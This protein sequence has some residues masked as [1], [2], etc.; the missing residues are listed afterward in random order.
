MAWWEVPV[1]IAIPLG[2]SFAINA[3]TGPPGDWYK[4]LNKPSWTPP[5][6]VFPVMWT[7]L[8]VLMG[9]A[10]WLVWSQGG[11]EE[12]TLPLSFYIAQLALNFLWT[13]LFFG[14]HQIGLAL[15]EIVLMWLAI[16]ATIFT[17]WGVSKTAAI[18]LLPYICWVSVATALNYSIYANNPAQGDS[19]SLTHPLNPSQ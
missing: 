10:S 15:V 12:Q 2:G 16:A 9:I 3:I 19:G 8:Y 11:F 4:S 1:A 17:F 18:L 5:N 6:W 13:P 7:T 14:L